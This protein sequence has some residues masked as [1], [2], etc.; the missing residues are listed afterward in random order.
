MLVDKERRLRYLLFLLSQFLLGV[1]K[2]CI[3][4]FVLAVWL[5]L[6]HLF[7]ILAA[8]EIF[9]FQIVNDVHEAQCQLLILVR[10]V[11]VDQK[12]AV[13][14]EVNLALKAQILGQRR[15]RRSVL[16][17]NM[18]VFR[19]S[20]G[21]G[22]LSTCRIAI[23][24]L[25]A[26]LH[27]VRQELLLEELEAKAR[28]HLVAELDVKDLLPRQPR[29]LEEE[30]V[31]HPRNMLLPLHAGRNIENKRAYEGKGALPERV[32]TML[33]QVE[34]RIDHLAAQVVQLEVLHQL[35]RSP[36]SRLPLIVLRNMLLSDIE[37]SLRNRW[38]AAHAHLV[39]L[40]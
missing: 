7:F 30:V 27:E 23:G 14:D 37:W 5:V 28:H 38:R 3:A 11:L 20:A 25:L 24:Q 2:S 6:L 34:G 18:V 12:Y 10:A 19:S 29:L 36:G 13:V 35:V 4:M 40:L 31:T 9:I 26:V 22:A 32:N 17:I 39:L 21:L 1:G 8:V 33:K 15:R 16:L